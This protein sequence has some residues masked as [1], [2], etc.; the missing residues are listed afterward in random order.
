MMRFEFVPAQMF[1]WLPDYEVYDPNFQFSLFVSDEPVDEVL[2][3]WWLDRHIPG[4][5]L[6]WRSLMRYQWMMLHQTRPDLFI[7]PWIPVARLQYWQFQY[8]SNLEKLR[9]E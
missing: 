5:S 6:L 8:Y 3:T 7:F 4:Y 2:G 9:R 1:P